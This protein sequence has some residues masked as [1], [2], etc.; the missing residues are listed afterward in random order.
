MIPSV[1]RVLVNF[2]LHAPSV[3]QAQKKWRIHDDLGLLSAAWIF[4]QVILAR[5]A[6]SETAFACA[7]GLG[8][9]F[10]L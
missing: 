2:W 6:L 3:D 8:C 1:S 5:L 4:N 7:R 10:A 9:P